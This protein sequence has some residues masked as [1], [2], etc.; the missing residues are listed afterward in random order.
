V[1][2]ALEPWRVG[3]EVL[4]FTNCGHPWDRRIESG[5]T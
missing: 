3:D 4:V 5:Q 1:R 2:R